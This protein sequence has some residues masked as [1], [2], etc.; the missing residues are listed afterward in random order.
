MDNIWRL[1]E[2]KESVLL[3]VLVAA[4]LR[5]KAES[6]GAKK[7]GGCVSVILIYADMCFVCAVYFYRERKIM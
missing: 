7:V 4:L 3:Q 2:I 5:A 6:S 1:K